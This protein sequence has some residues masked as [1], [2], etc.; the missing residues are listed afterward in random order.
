MNSRFRL[1]LTVLAISNACWA[2]AAEKTVIARIKVHNAA[3]EPVTNGIIRG[4]LPLPNGYDKPLRA[5]GVRVGGQT[6]AAQTSVMSTYPGSSRRFPVGSPE[7]I[8]LAFRADL[9]GRKVSEFEVVQA[10]TA[11]STKAKHAT[12]GEA[13]ARILRG[14]APLLLDAVDC[15]GNRYRAD[16]LDSE[17]L[18]ETRQAGPVLVERVYR[19]VLKLV[20]GSA[21]EGKPALQ[22]FLVV[23]AYLTTYADEEFASLALMI[24]NGTVDR[25]N[26]NVFYRQIR[27]GVARPAA[28]AVWRRKYSPAAEGKSAVEDG[29]TW[30][31]CPPPHPDGKVY[32][33]PYGSAAVLRG[34]L[35]AP[36]AEKRARQF[37]DHGP[38]F[39][40]VP[41]GGLFSWSNPATARYGSNKYPMPL[42]LETDAFDR[43]GRDVQ[44]RLAGGT[45]GWD[46]TYL[47]EKPKPR[48]RTMGHAM[49][50]GVAYGG[51]TGGQGIHYVYGVR[52]A[53]TGHSGLVRMHVLLADRNFDRQRVHL[54]HDDVRPYT[55][56]RRVVEQDGQKLLD[57]PYDHRGFPI[58]KP[59]DP[60]AAAQARHVKEA[61]LL[62]PEAA[63]LLRY[64]NHDD[65]HL[66]R[67]FDA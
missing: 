17:T 66:S 41:H 2:A 53:L 56:S 39:V 25:P 43:A 60:A 40:P 34:V 45:L 37:A 26:G 52:A 51:M 20:V 65:Q 28:L 24:H 18:L 1:I 22:R 48:S 58:L 19:S 23:R 50:A 67:V 63:G 36:R 32:V 55:H 15:H 31:T 9:P 62:A 30:L 6:A 12:P 11:P 42:A 57:V 49:P 27:V 7:V 14:D 59:A 13:L 4:A 44:G 38:L 21:D 35:F 46:L 61:G 16:V 47:R 54:F 29:Y 8:Q 3:S 33:M 10:E 5:I 64:H